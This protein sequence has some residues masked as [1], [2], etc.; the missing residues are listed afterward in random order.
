MTDEKLNE[1]ACEIFSTLETQNT[2]A[3]Q[4]MPKISE[5]ELL[6]KAIGYNL[7]NDTQTRMF[8]KFLSTATNFA[9][10]TFKDKLQIVPKI[11]QEIQDLIIEM[12]KDIK[13]IHEIAIEFEDL[14]RLFL[15]I[16]MSAKH[17]LN[18]IKPHLKGSVSI[19]F[20]S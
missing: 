11:V 20:V 5:E 8:I 4:D 19:W 18:M 6:N 16:V 7:E 14:L 1:K 13:D 2:W 9:S 12:K 10:T 15:R 3:S 17:N